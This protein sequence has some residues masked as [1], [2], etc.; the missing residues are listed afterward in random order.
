MRGRPQFNFPL[1]YEVEFALRDKYGCELVFNPARKDMETGIDLE[2]TTGDPAE[3][4]AQ[5][6]SLRE[7]IEW[8]LMAIIS[9]CDSLVLLPDWHQSK[10]AITEY[11]LARFLD[12]DVY[13]WLP[14]SHEL[15]PLHGKV[16]LNV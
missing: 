2:G 1:F 4:E 5:G 11:A 10:G 6:F 9:E 8:D 13:L 7:A 16:N 15:F 14:Y 12:L 3:L